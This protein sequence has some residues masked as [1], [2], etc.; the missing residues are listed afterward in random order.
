MARKDPRRFFCIKIHLFAYYIII[1]KQRY[2]GLFLKRDISL[3]QW[4]GFGVTAAGGTLLHFLYEWTGESVIASLVSGVNE[5]TWEHMKLMFFPMFIFAL[6]Q[7]RFFKDHASFWCVKLI[8]VL[9]GLTLIPIFFYTYN[10]VLGKSPDWVNISIFFISAALA[11]LLENRLFKKGSGECK[12]NKAAFILICIIGILFIVFT[13]IPPRI[14]L[15]EDPVTG[16]YG[17]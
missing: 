15:F 11:F 6:I 10:G 7:R 9:T 5:S 12:W 13:F 17:I 1:Y 2:G 16:Q 4:I 3:W 14:P 8:G